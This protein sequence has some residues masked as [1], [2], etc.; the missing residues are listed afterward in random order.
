MSDEGKT[1]TKDASSGGGSSSKSSEKKEETNR[2]SRN[3]TYRRI[4]AN[5]NAND[6]GCKTYNSQMSMRVDTQ[7]EMQ[8]PV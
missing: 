7:R 4:H 1:L 3:K 8:F 5:A 2:A 6:S